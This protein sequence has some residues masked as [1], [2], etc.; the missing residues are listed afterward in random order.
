MKRNLHAKKSEFGESQ[1]GR[2]ADWGFQVGMSLATLRLRL[3]RGESRHDVVSL[4]KAGLPGGDRTPDPQLRRLLLYPTELRADIDGRRF[5]AI[6][7]EITC[8]ALRSS[9]RDHTVIKRR[10]ATSADPRFQTRDGNGMPAFQ[11]TGRRR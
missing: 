7:F 5:R 10:H 11:M 4:G 9:G 1:T 3:K 6:V 8:E 2:L